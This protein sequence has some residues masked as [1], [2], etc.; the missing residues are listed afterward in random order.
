MEKA[1]VSLNSRDGIGQQLKGV[2]F[3]A[4][5]GM[6]NGGAKGGLGNTLLSQSSLSLLWNT[7]LRR[8]NGQE[9]FQLWSKTRTVQGL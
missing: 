8:A 1:V 9:R 7:L 3:S 2:A 4:E 6:L 5:P